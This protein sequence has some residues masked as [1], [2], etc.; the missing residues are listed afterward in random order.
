MK[1]D[2]FPLALIVAIVLSWLWLLAEWFE[3]MGFI[4][5]VG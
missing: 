2:W 1:L 4:G 3:F 5:R